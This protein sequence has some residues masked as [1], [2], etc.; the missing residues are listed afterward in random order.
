[1]AQILVDWAI[2]EPGDRV[3]DP[4]FGGLVFMQA[5]QRRLSEL[6]APDASAAHQIFGVDVDVGASERV[7]AGGLS[8]LDVAN[9]LSQDFFSVETSRLPQM[10]AVVGNPPYIR[11]QSFNASA[12]RARELSVAAGVK[13]SKLASSWAPFVIHATSFLATGGRLAQVLPA[14]LLHAQY[15]RPVLDFLRR[16]FDQITV[17]VFDERVFPGALEDVVLL[18][19]DGRGTPGVGDLRVSSSGTLADLA[20]GLGA[21]D[22]RFPSR[23]SVDDHGALLGQLLPADTLALYRG[24][25]DHEDVQRLGSLASVD[26]GIVTGANKFF[27][28]TESEAEELDDCLLR[29]A[30]GKAVQLAGARLAT[31]DHQDLLATG[32]PALM[33]AASREQPKRVLRT[34]A[35]HISRGEQEGF[36]ERYKCRIRDPWWELPLPSGGPP[37]LLLTYCSNEYPRIA[38]NEAAVISTNTLHGVRLSD[39]VFA[40]RLAAGFYNSLTLLS[41]EIV[42]RSYG[43]GVLKLEPTEAE[44]LLVPPLPPSLVALLPAV[45]EAIRSR[46]PQ[47]ALD[48]VDDLTL[49]PLGLTN[50]EIGDL[51]QAR[52]QLRERRRLRGRAPVAV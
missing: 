40:P 31:K 2:R 12:V 44:A 25:K 32:R 46:D 43:G 48:L 50:S 34:A 37:D 15:A 16:E 20:A 19:A 45:D 28:L 13:M 51:R 22:V 49:K 52:W 24:L 18:F 23:E 33:F 21:P 27:L 36:H 3:L 29:P 38:L 26:I 4:S 11:Y 10:D 41:A 47:H 30:I 14:E 42:G 35:R 9:F 8:N 7:A 17:A 1:M 39:P 5:S 6:G